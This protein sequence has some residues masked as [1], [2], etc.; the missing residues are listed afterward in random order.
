MPIIR[1]SKDKKNP[2]FMMNKTGINDPGL[3]LKAKGLLAYLISKPDGWYINYS[4][5]IKNSLNSIYSVRSAVSELLSHGYMERTQIR[6][7]D[8]QFGFYDYIVYEKP[9]LINIRK[10]NLSPHSGFPHT[11]LP[12]TDKHTL[13]NNDLGNIISTTTTPGGKMSAIQ[14]P[15][16]D[17]RYSKEEIRELKNLLSNLNIKNHKKLFEMFHI[18]QIYTYATWISSRKMNMKNPTGFFI[19]AIKENWIDYDETPDIVRLPRWWV[20][21][22]PCRHNY[23]Y[24]SQEPKPYTCPKCN[25]PVPISEHE[26]F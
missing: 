22:F 7:D 24:S 3:S 13:L 5:I 23:N 25:K 16:V 1:V 9:L 18:S 17:D 8:G 6:K 21:C 12:L 26:K 19:T 4:D 10:N 20:Y 14:D 15:V 2:Y 11:V